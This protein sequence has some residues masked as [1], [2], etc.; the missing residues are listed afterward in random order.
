MVSRLA[1]LKGKA[2]VSRLHIDSMVV[3]IRRGSLGGR[4]CFIAL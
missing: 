1:K 4:T 2:T 3:K